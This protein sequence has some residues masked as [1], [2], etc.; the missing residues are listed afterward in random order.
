MRL[1]LIMP[2]IPHNLSERFHTLH[3]GK[4]KLMYPSMT[5]YILAALTPPDIEVEIVDENID[6]LNFEKK[7]DL[8]GISLSSTPVS[9]RVYEIA[10]EFRKR[11]SKVILGGIHASIMPEEAIKHADSVFIGE[12]EP[13]WKEVIEDFNRGNL[14][15]F[16]RSNN[17]ADLSCQPILDDRFIKAERYVMGAL[18]ATR[19]CPHNCS[20][21]AGRKMYGQKLRFRPIDKIVEEVKNSPFKKFYFFDDNIAANKSYAK[22]LFKALI[23]LNIK[24]ESDVP[25]Y[26]AEDDEFLELASKSG[27]QSL[28]FGFES[29][30][31]ENLKAINKPFNRPEQ[32]KEVIKNVHS[33]GISVVGSFMFGLDHDDETILE[34]FFSFVDTSGI[35]AF[36][37][38]VVTPYPGTPFYDMMEEEGRII[39]KD[40]SKYD[41]THIVFQPKLISINSLYNIMLRIWMKTQQYWLKYSRRYR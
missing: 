23:P 15:E 19:G 14:K 20:F 7:A 25:V 37:A 26:A 12:A 32:Y 2:K 41:S 36:G 39:E 35:D 1:T 22:N 27:C 10:E 30:R 8:V 40:W 5:P 34:E 17:Y 9:P 3:R 6:E 33:H 28:S 13:M 4:K 24:W 11:G 29:V 21:C 18:Q 38:L 31:A 16:Y